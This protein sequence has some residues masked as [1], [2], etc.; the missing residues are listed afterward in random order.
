VERRRGILKSRFSTG[1]SVI[2]GLV[3]VFLIFWVIA[4]YFLWKA[5]IIRLSKAGRS[6]LFSANGHYGS[7]IERA[8]L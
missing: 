1:D 5:V 3:V 2:K 7:F 4:L 6:W 8:E